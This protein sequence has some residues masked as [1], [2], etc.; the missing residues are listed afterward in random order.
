MLDRQYIIVSHIYATGP[1]FPLTDHL[2]TRA[3][4]VIFI[5]HPFPYAPDTRSFLRVYRHGE[6]VHERLFWRWRGPDLAFYLKDVLLTLWWVLPR[7]KRAVFV[8]VDNLN[9]CVGAVLKRLGKVRLLVFYTIDYIPNRFQSRLLNRLYHLLDRTAVGAADYVWNLSPI[10]V[11]ERE[12]RGVSF[13]HRA[14]QITVPIGTVISEDNKTAHESHPSTVAFMGHLR[15]GQ[16]VENL[17]SA[18]QQVVR[19]I[20]TAQ[21][22]IIGGGPLEKTL[23]TTAETLGLKANV[24]F[25]GFVENFLDM[26]GMLKNASVAVA[27]YVDDTTTYTR[28]TDP[29]KI[30]DYLACGLPVV[31]TN[32]PHV[33]QEIEKR[34]CGFVV[35]DAPADLARGI[36]RLLN[37][38]NLRQEFR[39]NARKMAADYT[40]DQIFDRA[41]TR[42]L[43]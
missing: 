12:K 5:G 31:I 4:E 22:L 16:G 1:A 19:E 33:A 8:G 13:L 11:K 34:R 28:Y 18:M 21:L 43:S 7:A 36:I 29:G 23:Q 41:V 37:D 32:V 26:L 42:T 2:R 24:Q 38:N 6:L 30:K 40:W 14:K 27:P 20:P 35:A 15:A 25:T 9:A 17:L 10:M 3:R 39:A